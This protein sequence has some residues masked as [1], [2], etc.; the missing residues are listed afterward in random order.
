[1]SFVACP[2]CTRL[3]LQKDIDRIRGRLVNVNA[4]VEKVD[5]L[6]KLKPT[7][8]E[9]QRKIQTARVWQL[10]FWDC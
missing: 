4:D 7:L 5:G 3:G 2:V 9:L 1:M 8:E 10:T 6:K